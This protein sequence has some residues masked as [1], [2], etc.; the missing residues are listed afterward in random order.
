M[1][2][3]TDRQTCL[4]MCIDAKRHTQTGREYALVQTSISEHGQ[5]LFF[6]IIHLYW[7]LF[8]TAGFSLIPATLVFK[9]V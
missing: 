5:D 9:Y 6:E 7:Q 1:D 3:V 2:T 8:C 4:C